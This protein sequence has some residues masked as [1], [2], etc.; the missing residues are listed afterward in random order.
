MC[1]TEAHLQI[2]NVNTN[3]IYD[4]QILGIGEE[5]LAQSN[6]VL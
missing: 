2:T 6:I 5:P 4:Y 3:D 1:K